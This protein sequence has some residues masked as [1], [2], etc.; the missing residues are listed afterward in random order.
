VLKKE[1]KISEFDNLNDLRDSDPARGVGG[2]AGES[3]PNFAQVERRR[4]KRVVGWWAAFGVP[5]VSVAIAAFVFGGQSSSTVEVVDVKAVAAVPAPG[6]TLP[7]LGNAPGT[8][9]TTVAPTATVTFDANNGTGTITTQTANVS[10]VLISNSFNRTDYTFTGWNTVSGGGIGG[11]P[12]LD[13]A[14]YPFTASVTLYAQWVLT[15]HTE[16]P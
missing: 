14:S 15:D 2:N 7:I 3:L 4:R 16:V 12:Y 11:T 13:G 5:A 8:T 6:L 9:T 1:Q 10:T